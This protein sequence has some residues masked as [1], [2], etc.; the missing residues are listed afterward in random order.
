MG[1][2]AFEDR[3]QAHD[4]NHDA[5]D[6]NDHVHSDNDY[7]S[8]MCDVTRKYGTCVLHDSYISLSAAFYM[9]HIYHYQPIYHDA[10]ADNE[11]I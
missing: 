7:H 8:D 9:I 2:L 5:V 4:K 6:D 3:K 1:F 11:I 10:A